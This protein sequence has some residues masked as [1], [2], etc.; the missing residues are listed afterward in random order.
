MA[1]M[2]RVDFHS[3]PNEP[4]FLKLVGKVVNGNQLSDL[5]HSAQDPCCALKLDCERRKAQPHCGSFDNIDPQH[6][7]WHTWLTGK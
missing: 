4:Y 6:K 1:L 2:S 5:I 3:N 7:I